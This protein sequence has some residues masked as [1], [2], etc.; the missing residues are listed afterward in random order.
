MFQNGIVDQKEFEEMAKR[1]VEI[2]TMFTGSEAGK[3]FH[4]NLTTK[5]LDALI[6]YKWPDSKAMVDP[7]QGVIQNIK[8]KPG[9]PEI[10][11][12]GHGSH[13][14]KKSGVDDEGIEGTKDVRLKKLISIGQKL[15]TE[16][17]TFTTD[18]HRKK[19]S[20]EYELMDVK[21]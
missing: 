19:E 5:Q 20:I 2:N 10:K 9:D 6:H 21:C 7:L 4:R 18:W 15:R 12:K 13:A 14:K 17:C 3:S 8:M 11:K 1:V 16:G